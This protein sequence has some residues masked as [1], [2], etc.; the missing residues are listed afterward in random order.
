MLKISHAGCFG[1]SPAFRRNSRLKCAL[2]SKIAKKFT[3]TPLLRVQ[4]RWRSSMLTNL[5]STSPVL[6]MICSK[7]VPL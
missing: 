6:V 7:S 2:Q 1:L 3:K 5:K 4:G